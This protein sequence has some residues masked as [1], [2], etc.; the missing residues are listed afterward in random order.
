[1]IHM[2]AR[3][4]AKATKAA[5]LV[6]GTRP[7]AGEAEIDSRRVDKDSLFVAFAGEK[8]DGNS[9][10][11]AAL[12]AGAA[13]VCVSA[14]PAAATLDHARAMG[15]SVLRAVDDDCEEFLLCLAG[16]WR[17]LHPSWT[18]VAVTG[19]VGKTTTK[20][21]LKTGIATAKRVHATSGNHNNLIGL[22]MTVLSAPEDTEVLV[23]EC[24]M[25][26]KGEISRLTRCCRPALAVITNVGTSHIGF[27]GGRENIARAKAE[28]VEGMEAHGSIQP[29]LILGSAG[30]F[31][32][33]IS[34]QFARPAGVSTVCVGTRAEDVLRAED[35]SVNEESLPT[36]TFVA[37]DGW[38]KTVTLLVPGRAVVDDA[39]M[40][41]ETITLL[42]LDRDAAL[43]AIASMPAVS[44]RLSVLTAANGARIIDDSY[45]A[46]PNSV[47]A[48]LD[49]LCHM[50]A[51]GRRIAILGEIGE[52][53]A[54]EKRLHAYVGAYVA[55]KP[56]DMAVFVGTGPAREMA[57][58]ARVMGLSEDA[59][60]TFDTVEDL[61][62]IFAPVVEAGDVVLVK[63]SRSAGLDAFVK[64]V[65]ANDR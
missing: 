35:I 12:D 10:V 37:C 25:N 3:D 53:G 21:M 20:D 40:A 1:M 36:A 16:E 28:I 63:A 5:L 22:P 23:C 54:D 41:L 30:D 29:T 34:E 42:G 45:N 50:P 58:A 46:S 15:A 27:L 2:S 13:I 65:V 6:E 57:E 60:E 4:V 52:L 49:V 62:K 48:A 47:A 19:S 17:R 56:I 59:I 61:S 31:T 38:K 43:D 39:L 44:M 9:Y 32:S 18:V 14:E 11:D 26:H 51:K 55:A 8:V 7:L 64:G 24:G 33:F